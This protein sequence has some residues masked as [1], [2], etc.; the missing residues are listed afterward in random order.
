M[1]GEWVKRF[2]RARLLALAL[3]GLAEVAAG[4]VAGLAVMQPAS[5]QFLDDRFPFMDDRIRRK[6]QYQQQPESQPYNPFGSQDQPRQAPV[7]SS[8]APA[9]RKP[10]VPPTT[11]V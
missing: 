8:R 6:R 11:N 1:S 10:E 4:T 3:L 5:A 2:G 7:D 9:P